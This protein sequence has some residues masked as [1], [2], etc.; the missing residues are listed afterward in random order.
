MAKGYFSA[1]IHFMKKYG[2][3][4]DEILFSPT[5]KCNLNCG[6]C[7]IEKHPSSLSIK[8]ASKFIK[9][10]AKAKIKR[11]GFTGGEPFLAPDFLYAIT[12]ETVRNEMLF[13]R[14]MTNGVWFKSKKHLVTVLKKLFLAGYDGDICLSV[15]AFHNQN[16]K[17]IA[18][19]IKTAAD[20]WNRPDII[21]IVSV[22]GTKEDKTRKLL[23][24]LSH[25]L[26]ANS[27]IK[28]KQGDFIKNNRFF[29]KIFYID[30]S[31]IGKAA[32]LK[33][34]WDGKWFKDDFCKGPGNVF[35]VQ[36]DGTVKPCCGYSNDSDILTIGSIK[37]D[38]P[39][40][41]IINAEKNRFVSSIFK[42]GFHPIRRKLEKSGICFPGKTTNHCFFCYYLMHNIPKSILNKHI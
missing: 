37:R 13:S 10:C 24:K 11:V 4:P 6:H 41:L 33:N 30:I 17:K 23:R 21:S 1:I 20:I 35:F 36:P 16:I 22:K 14:I 9:E 42:S 8:T 3:N 25:I 5:T 7:G 19:F 39:K 15:D 18:L 34:P 38:T 27:S 12:K 2:F 31:P 29:I 32:S 28:F 40:K 26:N